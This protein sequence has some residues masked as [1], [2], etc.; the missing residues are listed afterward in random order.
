MANVFAVDSEVNIKGFYLC[1]FLCA[2][3]YVFP[4]AFGSTA[5]VDS[6]ERLSLHKYLQ[7]PCLIAACLCFNLKGC[8]KGEELSRSF[9]VAETCIPTEVGCSSVG[10][11]I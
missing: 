8:L 5:R 6:H 9:L 2:C 7:A 1:M 10:G 11:V 4:V 3:V